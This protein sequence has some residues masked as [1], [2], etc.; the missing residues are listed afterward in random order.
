VKPLNRIPWNE[1]TI[2]MTLTADKFLWYTM[3]LVVLLALNIVIGC[4]SAPIECPE[5]GDCT[6]KEE[7]ETVDM[8]QAGWSAA[9]R[10]LPGGRLDAL[11][12]QTGFPEIG[13]YT[14][15]LGLLQSYVHSPT[16][17]TRARAEIV[18]SLRGNNVRRLVDCVSGLSISG[19]AESVNVKI[20]DDSNFNGNAQSAY[21]VSLQVGR[22][23]RP[24][25]ERPPTLVASEDSVNDS[26]YYITT[27]ADP[28]E[29]VI[30][31]V[32][33]G[34]ISVMVTVSPNV[35]QVVPE[36]G[37]IVEQRNGTGVGSTLLKRYDPRQA[38]FVPLAPGTNAIWLIQ[39]PVSVLTNFWTVTYGI[40]G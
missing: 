16:E 11:A 20:Y 9:K 37:V 28:Q 5:T 21:N 32:D 38:D 34:I 25:V 33:S 2:L 35:G 23:V 22:G 3:R 14:I 26:G 12:F 8:T 18:W 27:F 10:L 17:T 39:D 40:D 30:A 15:Q 36:Y 13:V 24:A 31:P 19:L 6:P 4:G 7:Q 29:V 1:G